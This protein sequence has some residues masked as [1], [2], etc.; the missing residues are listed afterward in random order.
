MGRTRAVDDVLMHFG[1]KGMKWGVRKN[2]EQHAANK[3][4]KLD[5]KFE[6]VANKADTHMRLW[7]HSVVTMKKSGDLKRIN[8]KPEYAASKWRLKFGVAKRELQRKYED[9]IAGK[10]MEHLKKNAN[11]IV[12]RSATRKLDV[13]QLYKDGKVLR[14]SKSVW[15][16]VTVPIKQ[17]DGGSLVI[18]LVR[19]EFD[20]IIDMIPEEDTTLEQGF[21]AAENVLAHFGIK[22]MKWGQRKARPVSADAKQKQGVKDRVKKNK[23]GSVSNTDLQAAIRRMQLEQDFKRLSVNERSGVARWISSAMLE[24][25]KKE[26][27]AYAAKKVASVVAKKVATAGLA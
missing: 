19:D 26:V 4:R 18:R 6:K 25:G 9:E 13:E 22:G 23:V 27:Q 7:T 3:I 15:R 5:A 11:E 12:N 1:I 16:I 17:A 2:P 24:I 14:E 8:D 10:L 20:R 21:D